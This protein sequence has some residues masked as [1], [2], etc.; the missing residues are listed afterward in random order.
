MQHL[1]T[2]LAA[3]L[4]NHEHYQVCAVATAVVG[5]I[6]RA[7]G[8]QIM[9]YADNIVYLLLEALQSTTLD[10]TVKPPI[11]SCFG[12]VAMSATGDFEKYLPQVMARMQQ[13]A[14]SS[15]QVD[16]ALDDYDMQ[17]WLLSLRE[18]IFEAY[19]GVINGL[20][21]DN[22]QNLLVPYVEWL[23]Q[24][25]EVVVTPDSPTGQIGCEL[26]VKAAAGV[27][28]DL[29][30]ALPAIRMDLSQRMWIVQLLERGGQAK[31][32]RTREMASFAQ[33]TIFSAN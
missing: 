33:Q 30:D 19:I 9:L 21:A 27:L 22:K 2:P 14:E 32:I 6:C 16:V 25:C 18:S 29:V 17:D 11:L 31:D 7:L 10:K 8:S 20:A 12:D 5:D 24:F 13:A 1:M 26:L 23:L 15:I 3:A 4:G 28:G